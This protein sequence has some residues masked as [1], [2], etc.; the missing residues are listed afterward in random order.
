[1]PLLICCY[2]LQADTSLYGIDWNG[3]ISDTEDQIDITD[4]LNPLQEPDFL[5]LQATISPLDN[6]ECHGVDV[7]LRCLQ[8][9]CQKM[10]V[11]V[12]NDSCNVYSCLG[13]IN[14]IG[15]QLII[16]ITVA[17]CMDSKHNSSMLC[18]CTHSGIVCTS[19]GVLS[20]YLSCTTKLLMLV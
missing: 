11:N 7:F 14:F 12:K 9:V 15:I 1:M 10:F 4:T 19:L 6:S 18:T 16:I 3:P 13:L 2:C 5:Q 20:V 17:Y 8:F